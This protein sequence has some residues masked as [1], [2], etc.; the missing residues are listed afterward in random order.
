M[1]FYILQNSVKGR[2]SPLAS[3]PKS[4]PTDY[5]A[6][7]NPS[8]NSL[9]TTPAGE[10]ALYKV[11]RQNSVEG[12]GLD[13]S[14]TSPPG[15]AD[16]YNIGMLSENGNDT[17]SVPR[18][19]QN[20]RDEVDSGGTVIYHIPSSRP[21]MGSPAT[22]LQRDDQQTYKVP[23][24]SLENGL[25]T[26][27]VPQAVLENH[28]P[29]EEDALYKTPRAVARTLSPENV[30]HAP[31]SQDS[32][33]GEYDNLSGTSFPSGSRM[34]PAQDNYSVPRPPIQTPQEHHR[35]PRSGQ[36]DYV[37]TSL[38]RY[39][40]SG[41]LRPSRS[42]ES[43]VKR[44]IV[45]NQDD[46]SSPKHSSAYTR[47]TPSPSAR[48]QYFEIDIPDT[49]AVQGAGNSRQPPENLYAEISDKEPVRP[50]SSTGYAANSTRSTKM[51]TYV[52]CPQ[53]PTVDAVSS[54]LPRSNSVTATAR[55]LHRQGY[56]LVFPTEDVSRQRAM[57]QQITSIPP[58]NTEKKTSGS[59]IRHS[60]QLRDE[61]KAFNNDSASK[62][63]TSG[64]TE[65]SVLGDEYIIIRRSSDT[66]QQS[67]PQDIPVPLPQE[68]RPDSRPA[69]GTSVPIPVQEA[70]YEVMGS[71]QIA[72]H[73]GADRSRVSLPA[74]IS[75][76][77]RDSGFGSASECYPKD[78]G[79][80]ISVR[81]SLELD[82]MSM[83]V[84]EAGSRTSV[85]SLNQLEEVAGPMSPAVVDG[86]EPK[87]ISMYSS[88]QG[89][90]ARKNLVRIASGS[91]QDITHSKALRY[92]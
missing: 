2:I 65:P 77:H 8:T 70:E 24:A 74:L 15:K 35:N 46:S 33:K 73:I 81:D 21:A 58:R 20:G 66:R 82:S 85:G 30:Y 84:S 69:T 18:A 88:P 34:A 59:S 40:G 31:R 71:V 64:P 43:L 4:Q 5:Y 10:E 12:G 75:A 68:R 25:N 62:L 80:Q 16:Y 76:Q 87:S 52:T 22:Y 86:K 57:T 61:V 14:T 49:T 50:N 90:P 13:G 28:S 47:K 23:R 54:Q 55:A 92:A 26:Y 63:S 45:L 78:M 32:R 42:L 67:Q 3:Q 60:I 83:C 36:Y 41:R 53:I 72:K 6:V 27:S 51:N 7:P 79:R 44:R 11:P 48:H 56:E 37:D 91:P 38:P 17:Y 39:T 29:S 89:I 1:L 19:Q 9:N